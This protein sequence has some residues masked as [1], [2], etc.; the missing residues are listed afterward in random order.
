MRLHQQSRQQAVF[1]PVGHLHR[2]ARAG[3]RAE[4]LPLQPHQQ[5]RGADGGR[6]G[7]SQLCRLP[8]GAEAPAGE[9]VPGKQQPDRDDPPV[10]LH[11]ALPLYGDGLSPGPPGHEGQPLPL[12]HPGD[13]HGRGHRRRVRPPGRPGRDLPQRDKRGHRLPSF[14]KPR[15]GFPRT[16]HRAAV[17]LCAGGTPPGLPAPGERSQ[18]PGLSLSLL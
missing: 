12:R 1:V 6:P 16:G 17:C 3:E 13:Q 7:V 5:G 4:H 9:S 14:G 11:P 2:G 10:R 18:H 8:A 15:S